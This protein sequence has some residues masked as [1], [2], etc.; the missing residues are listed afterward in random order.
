VLV[1]NFSLFSNPVAFIASTQNCNT[2]RQSCCNVSCLHPLLVQLYFTNS[3]IRPCRQ[4][5]ILSYTPSH[6]GTTHLSRPEHNLTAFSHCGNSLRLYLPKQGY[7]IFLGLEYC[8]RGEG[9]SEYG[10][11]CGA[12]IWCSLWSVA[13]TDWENAR[14]HVSM[15]EIDMAGLSRFIVHTRGSMF[16]SGVW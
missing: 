9:E 16:G 14:V 13:C 10:M 7:G 12:L 15:V 5:L 2:N 3:P 6:S 11:R 4:H 1:C 8:V